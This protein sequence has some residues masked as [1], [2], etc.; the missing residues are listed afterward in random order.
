MKG[1]DLSVEIK[2]LTFRNPILPG[3]T[4]IVLD[5]RGG[6]EMYR[7]RYNRWDSSKTLQARKLEEIA[8]FAGLLSKD[9]EARR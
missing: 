8:S 2:G 1:I 6:C 4:D 9:S 5:A 7:A 3:S